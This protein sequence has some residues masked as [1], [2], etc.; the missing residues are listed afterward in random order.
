MQRLALSSWPAPALHL[1]AGGGGGAGQRRPVA[2][3]HLHRQEPQP[4][5][6]GHLPARRAPGRQAVAGGGLRAAG[7]PPLPGCRTACHDQVAPGARPSCLP[8]CL[9]ARYPPPPAATR[10]LVWSGL[11]GDRRAAELQ[12]LSLL[13][14]TQ[15]DRVV[16]AVEETL[17]GHT[18]QLLA[19]KALPRLDLPKVGGQL[20]A[21]SPSLCGSCCAPPWRRLPA[22]PACLHSAW[23]GPACPACPAWLP[24]LPCRCG[25]TATSRSCPS[26]PAAWAPAPIAKPST[27]ADTSAATTR[28]PWWSGRERRRQ[29]PRQGS[30]A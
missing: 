27:R 23:P 5:C 7:A 19:K 4:I 1:Q 28:Q 6:H 15:I 30:G 12:G 2:A 18:V 24:C 20:A 9:P 29:T 26:P 17:K 11:Q 16:E 14:V 25:A 8:A 10:C 21:P 3:Q 13:G 22:A